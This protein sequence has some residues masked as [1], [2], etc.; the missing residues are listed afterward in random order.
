MKKKTYVWLLSLM[1]V[2][3]C[4][5]D[6]AIS[7]DSDNENAVGNDPDKEVPTT[8]NLSDGFKAV[9][10]QPIIITND[11]GVASFYDIDIEKINNTYSRAKVQFVWLKPKSVHNNA[12]YNGSMELDQMKKWLTDNG[13]LTG[14]NDIVNLVYTENLSGSS[15]PIGK[16]EMPG[17]TTFI[18]FDS[19]PGSILNVFVVCHEVGH[20]FGLLHADQDSNV[21]DDLP[22][23]MGDGAYEDRLNPENSFNDYQ[24]GIIN[25]AAILHSQ[26]KT[27][28]LIEKYSLE[29]D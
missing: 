6:S 27:I 15:G 2:M 20:N 21:P 28:E 16:A 18:A 24:I 4:S 13:H 17:N 14:E 25:Q 22:N 10:V 5:K 11:D 1:L 23:V 12:I 29:V 9:V 3:G 7:D 26:E 8:L 19:N